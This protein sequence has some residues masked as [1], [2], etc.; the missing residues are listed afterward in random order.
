MGP[1]RVVMGLTPYPDSSSISRFAAHGYVVV[2]AAMTGGPY[3]GV[4]QRLT[5][6]ARP[7]HLVT[8]M[9]KPSL[10][11]TAAEAKVAHIR[12]LQDAAHPSTVPR[13]SAAPHGSA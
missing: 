7:P 9:P 2:V 8:I 3:D 10:Q 13:P 6:A 11:Q 1:H 4:I 5:A 12:L